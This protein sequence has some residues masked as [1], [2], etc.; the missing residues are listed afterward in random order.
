MSL[1]EITL[2]STDG[3]LV[4]TNN[5]GHLVYPMLHLD[6]VS[7]IPPVITLP[8]GF[9]S[10]SKTPMDKWLLQVLLLRLRPLQ[11]EAFPFRVTIP[12]H[13]RTLNCTF[14]QAAMKK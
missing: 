6:A 14:I 5:N 12:Q 3:V 13:L 8:E 4:A 9:T 1:Q 2:Q 11:Y 10:V 7:I